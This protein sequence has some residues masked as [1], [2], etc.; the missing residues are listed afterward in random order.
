MCRG[1]QKRLCLRWETEL[2]T[3]V[4]VQANV[5]YWCVANGN[6]QQHQMDCFCQKLPACL[7]LTRIYNLCYVPYAVSSLPSFLHFWHCLH[8]W[9]CYCWNA[10]ASLEG[11]HS[12]RDPT[13]RTKKALRATRKEDKEDRHFSQLLI[14]ILM[15]KWRMYHSNCT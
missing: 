10:S 8:C 4:A 11:E 9:R 3:R 15:I 5:Y 13:K 12:C 7:E 14:I 2:A 1:F 6:H